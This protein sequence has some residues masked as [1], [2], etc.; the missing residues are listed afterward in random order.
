MK[1]HIQAI[2]VSALREPVL[3][4]GAESV[5]MAF[6]MVMFHYQGRDCEF[7]S[8]RETDLYQLQTGT[9]VR[10]DLET[11]EFH[12]WKVKRQT[13]YT[14]VQEMVNLEFTFFVQLCLILLFNFVATVRNQI[15]CTGEKEVAIQSHPQVVNG[16]DAQPCSSSWH[17]EASLETTVQSITHSQNGS[18]IAL[19]LHI[20]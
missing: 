3:H 8:L 7:L 5:A 17:K 18:I 6:S 15:V 4:V 13:P 19:I 2:R 20:C 16:P 9:R 11:M 14:L 10:F 1:A 12:I